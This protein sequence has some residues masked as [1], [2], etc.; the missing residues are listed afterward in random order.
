M[1]ASIVKRYSKKKGAFHLT[2]RMG[3]I[4]AIEED[5]ERFRQID[6]DKEKKGDGVHIC[7]FEGE[8]RSCVGMQKTVQVSEL[9]QWTW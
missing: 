8:I 5:K 4:S 7:F 3:T 6:G 9:A 2:V 1:G